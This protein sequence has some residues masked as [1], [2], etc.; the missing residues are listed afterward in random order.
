M[1]AG[2]IQTQTPR[3]CSVYD[4]GS[5]TLRHLLLVIRFPKCWNPISHCAR[6]RPKNVNNIKRNLADVITIAI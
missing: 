3:C 4:L 2:E 6:L 1:K 5:L